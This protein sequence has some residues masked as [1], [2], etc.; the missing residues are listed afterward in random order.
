[1]NPLR[2]LSVA[3]LFAAGIS[4]TSRNFEGDEPFECNDGADNDR[5]GDFDC[6]D[7]DCAASPD[8]EQTNPGDGPGG[9]TDTD[10]PVYPTVDPLNDDPYPP[11]PDCEGFEGVPIPGATGW[12]SDRFDVRTD[13][14]VGTKAW[15]IL[16]NQA[17]REDGETEDCIVV[18]RA[19][20]SRGQDCGSCTYTLALDYT[21]DR[22]GTTCSDRFLATTNASFSLDLNVT[23]DVR[24]EAVVNFANSGHIHGTGTE[25]DGVLAWRSLPRCFYF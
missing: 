4:C 22:D 20:G 9:D 8:C 24:D 14:I 12:F 11:N 18:W 10:G 7:A 25:E 23:V 3:A 17:L 16:P 13:S 15:A 1:M 6:D 21:L 19:T 2:L 5:D